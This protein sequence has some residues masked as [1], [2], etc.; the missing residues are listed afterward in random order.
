MATEQ[1]IRYGIAQA[2][3]DAAPGAIVVPRNILNIQDG[4]WLGILQSDEPTP[5]VHGWMVALAG[6]SVTEAESYGAEYE[7]RYHV[8]QFFQYK[9]GVEGQ[10]SEDEM[11]TEREAVI[12]AFSNPRALT[13]TTPDGTALS[14]LLAWV[15]PLDFYQIALSVDIAPVAVHVAKGTAKI[16]WETTC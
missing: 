12:Q 5:R 7:L 13:G 14:E 16:R 6:Q 8:W 1:A 11:S 10:N 2:I 9:T 3:R 4:G 15:Q